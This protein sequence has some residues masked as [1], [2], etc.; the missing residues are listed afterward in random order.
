V[1]LKWFP[2][3]GARWA[4]D[5]GSQLWHLALPAFAIGLGWVG[6]LARLVRQQVA[7]NSPPS[8]F[9]IGWLDEP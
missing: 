5:L 1:W 4:G 3:I 8:S 7:I 9:A 2:A 6:F